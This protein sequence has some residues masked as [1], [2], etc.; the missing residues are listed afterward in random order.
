[1]PF[2][3]GFLPGDEGVDFG[4]G[5][6][7]VELADGD[8]AREEGVDVE[9]AGFGAL[10]EEL[11]D[12]FDP[13]HELGEEAVVMGVDFVDEFVEVVFVALAEV[14]EGLDCLVGVGGDVLFTAFVDDLFSRMS[15]KYIIGVGRGEHTVIIS[16]MK[17]AKSVTLLYTFADLY[18]R[19]SGS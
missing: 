14:D 1:V 17:T 15:V 18:T 6:V 8:G 19:T 9:L 4:D 10:A 7:L 2:L 5:F 11:E 13:A 12:T 16:S 3:A